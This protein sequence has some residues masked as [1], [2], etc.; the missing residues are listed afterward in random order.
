MIK[1]NGFQF[2]SVAKVGS[3]VHTIFYFP[4]LANRPSEKQKIEIF[5]E[6]SAASH[7]LRS[8]YV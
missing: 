8:F 3:L 5:H 6:S 2:N 1:L 7:I 4:P